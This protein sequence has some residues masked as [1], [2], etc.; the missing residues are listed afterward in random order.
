VC[1]SAR[2]RATIRERCAISSVPPP[3][4]LRVSRRELRYA[5]R[6]EEVPTDLLRIGWGDI[7]VDPDGLYPWW[8]GQI[9]VR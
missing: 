8:S 7:G 5:R 9:F 2:T 3:G 4:D 6:G 1:S